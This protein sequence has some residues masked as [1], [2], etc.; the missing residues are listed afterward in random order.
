MKLP[1][2]ERVDL[3]IVKRVD[4]SF[5]RRR[6]YAAFVLI[7]LAVV[8]FYYLLLARGGYVSRT[9]LMVERDPLATAPSF[10]N[11]LLSLA[12]GG[13]SKIDA[14]V[15]ADF[16]QS[17][18]MLEYLDKQLDLRAHYSAP[19]LDFVSR[20][21][22]SASAEKFL[23]YYRG[24]LDV[25]VDDDS[26]IIDLG[27]AAFDPELAKRM[28]D[29]IVKRSEEFV[30]EISRELAMQEIKFMQSE[31]DRVNQRLKQASRDLATLQAQYKMVSPEEETTMVTQIIA[32]MQQELSSQKAE[33]K[34]LQGYMNDG[35]APIVA[36]KQRI[37]ALERQIEQER[38]RQ[39]GKTPAALNEL[40]LKYQEAQMDVQVATDSYQGALKTM[41]E[42]RLEATRNVKHLVR[43]AAPSR[44][45]KALLPRRA[46]SVLLAFL[47][48]NLAYFV[49]T[50]V[51]AT[52]QDHRD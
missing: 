13:S 11:G 29:L 35:S 49:G 45:D 52:V 18:T 46:Y 47:L 33:L 36:A 26:L 32:G 25:Q 34:T 5:I 23:D 21:S 38:A 12:S 19:R 3:S 44:P 2:I 50:L 14:L 16:I 43:I 51:V 28:S 10:E 37:N 1:F 24:R 41:E 22:E 4:L 20:L 17:R 6:P 48:L 42:A 9:E 8:A 27:V 7:P 15:V 30:N 40:M 39:V 31:L